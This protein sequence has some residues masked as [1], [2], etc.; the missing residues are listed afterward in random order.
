MAEAALYYKRGQLKPQATSM[1]V[2]A[3]YCQ[4]LSKQA[5]FMNMK[6]APSIPAAIGN[7]LSNLILDTQNQV[8]SN[9]LQNFSASSLINEIE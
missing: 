7:S 5:F 1:F 9:H 6:V 2:F 3:G 8:S 4:S